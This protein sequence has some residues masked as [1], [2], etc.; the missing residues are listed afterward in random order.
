MHFYIDINKWLPKSIYVADRFH[1]EK[2][3]TGLCGKD[4]K[5]QK[6]K[7]RE[8][9]YEFDYVKVKELG[10]EILAEEMKKSVRERK[11][12]QLLKFCVKL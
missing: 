4:D 10:Y 7:I 6:S 3:L 5:E 8:A 11:L 12:K 2:A 1:L 9:M